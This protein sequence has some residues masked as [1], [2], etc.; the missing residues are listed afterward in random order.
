[1]RPE[2]GSKRPASANSKVRV[3]R[4]TTRDRRQQEVM[5]NGDDR[6]SLLQLQREDLIS[7][8]ILMKREHRM[9]EA[10]MSQ[11]KTENQRIAAESKQQQRRIEKI[12]G[13]HQQPGTQASNEA[14]RELEKSVI[15]RQLKAQI[16]SFKCLLRDKDSEI[17]EL[18]KSV[19]QTEAVELAIEKEEYFLEIMRLRK[20]LQEKIENVRDEQQVREWE[21]SVAAGVEGELKKEI[22]R[23]SCGYQE[24]LERLK[25]TGISTEPLN[26]A[27]S[28]ARTKK[29]KI[30]D[31]MTSSSNYLDETRLATSEPPLESLTRKIDKSYPVNCNSIEIFKGDIE[32]NSSFG[33]D[34][35]NGLDTDG[36]VFVDA[37]DVEG[38][39]ME[40]SL[41]FLYE[42]NER[43]EG[44]FRGGD[45]WYTCVVKGL[46]LDDGTYDLRY[47]N[48]HSVI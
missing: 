1:M 5:A 39:D 17:Q 25:K 3:T 12:I 35:G 8:I 34:I 15:V 40:Q 13:S 31:R 22:D 9:M 41:G 45:R 27:R 23:L 11:I 20:I 32:S 24:L 28:S 33:D 46:N 16:N 21:K 37:A 26:V 43:V 14:R 30:K 2:S 47:G 48:C 42:M 7:T 36:G 4:T 6:N 10:Q 38:I 29:D 19:R 44:L 18:R